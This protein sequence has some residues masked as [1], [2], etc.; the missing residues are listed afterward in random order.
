MKP[1]LQ[2][3]SVQIIGIFVEVEGEEIES[4]LDKIFPIITQILTD[5]V[6]ADE[7]A[8]SSDSEDEAE[9]GERETKPKSKVTDKCLYNA[10]NCVGKIFTRLPSLITEQR[11]VETMNN[12][13]C[14]F[15]LKTIYRV[16]QLRNNKL[17]L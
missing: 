3:I 2:Q 8:E 14:K 1:Q 4:R 10:L 12:Y 7:D 15:C 13:M 6:K 5:G 17:S 9:D 11:F 16:Y